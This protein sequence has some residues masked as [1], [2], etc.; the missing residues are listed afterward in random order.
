M[1]R[2]IILLVFFI[3]IV[4][5][6]VER[7]TIKQ[8]IKEQGADYLFNQ[9]KNNEL[10]FNT[11]FGKFS[12]E[13]TIDGET[14]TFSGNIYIVKDTLIWLSIQKI[15]LEAARMLLTPDTAKFMNRINK[16]FFIG[17]FS[18]INK[19]FNTD[20]DFDIVQSII[21]GND[22]AYYDNS[23]FKA[24]IDNN[25]M[26]KLS[27]FNR[28]K[29]KK[30]LKMDNDSSRVLTQDIWLDPYTF[31]ISKIL[32]KEVKNENRKLVAEYDDYKV[33]EGQIYPSSIIFSILE[34]KKFIVKINFNK[35]VFNSYES[36]PYKVPASY[37]KATNS[38]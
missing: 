1:K 17:D 32:I 10:K 25:M 4:G 35:V 38:N 18:Y 36:K 8:P 2:I 11:F 16:T 15:G 30:T 12:A 21:I 19:L 31:K 34:D 24:S 9:L 13:A 3:S 37:Q 5:C 23:K 14:N 27:T 33:E 28:R 7:K 22:M 20:F 6:S 26:Y 29:L